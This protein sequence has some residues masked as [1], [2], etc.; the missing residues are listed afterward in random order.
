MHVE[1]PG[2][3]EQGGG[4]RPPSGPE[5]RERRHLLTIETPPKGR[6]PQATDGIVIRE[7][8]VGHGRRDA[9]AYGSLQRELIARLDHLRVEARQICESYLANFDSDVSTLADFLDGSSEVRKPRDMKAATM[10]EWAK[11]L[12]RLSVK[13][14][15]G[16]RKDL[17]RID[18]AVRSLMQSA[19]E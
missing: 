14:N 9:D 6:R 8:S 18:R 13:P 4:V 15:K 17:G 16:R 1:R 12:D 19:F 3:P 7:K 10:E 11:I 2:L 5:N